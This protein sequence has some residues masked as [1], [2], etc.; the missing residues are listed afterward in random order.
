MSAMSAESLRELQVID[1]NMVIYCIRLTILKTNQECILFNRQIIYR[2]EGFPAI[3]YDI[4]RIFPV[5][6]DKITGIQ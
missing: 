4:N 5:F 6:V 1:Q 2:A 3:S